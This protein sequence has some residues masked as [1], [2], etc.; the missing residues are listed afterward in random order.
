V[1]IVSRSGQLAGAGGRRRHK[2][3]AACCAKC[4]DAGAELL[5][6]LG[7]L[8]AAPGRRGRVLRSLGRA[9]QAGGV[10]KHV[11]RARRAAGGLGDIDT[12]SFVVTQGAI[13]A[14]AAS[15]D[16][17]VTSWQL[18][19]A[20]A[21][22]RLPPS[23]VQQVDGFIERWRKEKD[24]FYWFQTNRL[25]ALLSFEAEFNRTR[26]QFLSYGQNTAIAPAT[27][28]AGGQTVRADQIPAGSDWFS[29]VRTIA[30]WGGVIVGGAAVLKIS[31]DL[32]VFK[33]I[34]RLVGPKGS[35]A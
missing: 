5:G 2:G 14:E 19:Y 13:D 8:A 3:T 22:A 34:G 32:G 20:T 35:P 4:A 15:F 29:Q 26:D 10:A 9:H 7:E 27:V 18:D 1:A 11:H 6:A 23:F 30:I 12:S 33:G 25:A 24:A 16:D 21:A 31:S 17:R 28:T